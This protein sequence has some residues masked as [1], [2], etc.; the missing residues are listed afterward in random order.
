MVAAGAAMPFALSY[1]WF[2]GH[3]LHNGSLIDFQVLGEL[4]VI[5]FSKR[6]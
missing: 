6:V 1:P 4:G 5:C 2:N 3:R